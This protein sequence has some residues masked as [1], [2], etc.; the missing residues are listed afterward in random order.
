M[1][2]ITFD[3]QSPSPAKVTLTRLQNRTIEAEIHTDRIERVGGRTW[4][5]KESHVARLELRSKAALQIW[6]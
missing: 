4:P 1:R 3:G 5:A 2:H 6:L